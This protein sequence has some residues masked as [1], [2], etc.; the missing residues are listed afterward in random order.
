MLCLACTLH[1]YPQPRRTRLPFS[2]SLSTLSLRVKI[3]VSRSI[4]TSGPSSTTSERRRPSRW[5]V[6]RLD[7]PDLATPL[8]DAVP[9]DQA[10]QVGDRDSF[11]LY[12][13]DRL[14]GKYPVLEHIEPDILT[15]FILE[16]AKLFLKD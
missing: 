10:A 4:G 16:I 9:L 2:L 7:V 13:N 8:V 15:R 5:L 11:T 1:A 6:V 3:S 12:A 14:H